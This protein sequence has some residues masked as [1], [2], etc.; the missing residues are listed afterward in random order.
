MRGLTKKQAQV[1]AFIQARRQRTGRAPSYREIAA[2]LGVTVR[3]A[4]Q[5][6]RA[7]EHKGVLS[8]TRRNRGIHLR[9]SLWR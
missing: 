2:Y 6:V 3:A 7:L 9:S 8:T 4:Y 1:L 5:H